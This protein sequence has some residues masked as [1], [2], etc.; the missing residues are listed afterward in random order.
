MEFLGVREVVDSDERGVDGDDGEMGE[1][2]GGIK[3]C[4]NRFRSLHLST[5]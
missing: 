2:I 5:M 4:I 3:V 1:E